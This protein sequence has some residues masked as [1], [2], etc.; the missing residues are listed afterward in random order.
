M[1]MR[2]NCLQHR[3]PER[4]YLKMKG[5]NWYWMQFQLFLLLECQTL[6]GNFEEVIGKMRE[7]YADNEKRKVA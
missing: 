7:I 6:A 1:E 3:L 5:A 2:G 4:G